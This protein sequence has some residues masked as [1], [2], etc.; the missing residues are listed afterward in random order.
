MFSCVSFNANK[1]DVVKPIYSIG[2]FMRI[3]FAPHWDPSQMV[4]R[5]YKGNTQK[6]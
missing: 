3:F 4:P 6:N 2:R 1:I 5:A